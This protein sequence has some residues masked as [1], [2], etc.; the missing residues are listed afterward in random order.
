MQLLVKHY[1]YIHI[2][3]F[4]DYNQEKIFR[5]VE[6]IYI[7]LQSKVRCSESSSSV[8]SHYQLE[9][10]SQGSIYIIGN[11]RIQHP[12]FPVLFSALLRIRCSTFTGIPL[13]LV[14]IFLQFS[15]FVF[16]NL[17]VYTP[18]NNIKEF[19]LFYILTTIYYLD[20]LFQPSW[21]V[22]NR[23]PL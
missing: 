19:M 20:F 18:V 21:W 14:V 4:G 22:C 11:T 16:T 17:P 12:A 15:K 10:G 2:H 13:A 23:M 7:W 9:F 8:M 6:K 3:L 1:T 5:I